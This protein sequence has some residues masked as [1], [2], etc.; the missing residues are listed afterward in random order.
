MKIENLRNETKDWRIELPVN[1]CRKLQEDR[2][3]FEGEA[4]S[5]SKENV[6]SIFKTKNLKG[7]VS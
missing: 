5:K 4:G 3:N 7:E 2:V 1:S 6:G